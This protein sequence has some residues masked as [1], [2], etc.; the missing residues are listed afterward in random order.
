MT[1]TWKWI[2]GV[3]L[4]AIIIASIAYNQGWLK[5]GNLTIGRTRK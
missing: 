4:A 1:T 3:S 5:F 2:I